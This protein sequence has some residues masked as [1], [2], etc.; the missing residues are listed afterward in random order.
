M[1]VTVYVDDGREAGSLALE[2]GKLVPHPTTAN[3]KTVFDTVMEPYRVRGKTYT[4][5]EPEDFLR[6]LKF[7]YHGSR[8]RAGSMINDE[9]KKAEATASWSP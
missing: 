6:N 9:I 7:Q 4:S 2:N 1:K 8:L 3:D 5:D